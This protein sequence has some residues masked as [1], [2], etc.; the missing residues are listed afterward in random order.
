MSAVVGQSSPEKR[1]KTRVSAL[2][3]LFCSCTVFTVRI[4]PVNYHDITIEFDGNISPKQ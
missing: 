1:L 4:E 2:F 3:F